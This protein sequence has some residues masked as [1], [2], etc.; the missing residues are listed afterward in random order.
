MAMDYI[1][2]LDCLKGNLEIIIAKGYQPCRQRNTAAQ[3]A[4]GEILI[5]FDNDSCP[6]PN[7]SR[8]LSS[9]FDDPNVSAVGG[10]NPA[11]PT[12]KFFPNL[13][14]AVLTSRVAVLS[15]ATRY[16]P[17]GTLR[18]ARDS[19]LILCNFAMRRAD[20]LALG[21][22]H[23]SLSPNEENEFFERFQEAGRF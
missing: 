9:H 18:Q 11:L 10:P 15:K 12:N 3:K 6:K 13:V 23:E 21:G 4:K 5:F 17:T 20:Y 1:D 22:L 8:Q 7:Y 14:E 19:E 16:K 2:Q